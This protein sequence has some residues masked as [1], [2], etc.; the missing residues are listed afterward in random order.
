MNFFNEIKK[1]FIKNKNVLLLAFLIFI[2]PFLIGFLFKP[3]FYNIFE[4]IY[5]HLSQQLKEGVI[6]FSFAGIFL[7]NLAVLCRT[8]I[9]GAIFGISAI[10]LLYNALS[11]GY[12]L[13]GEQIFRKLLLV[14]PHGIFEFSSLIIGTA[15][16]FL[17][18]KFLYNFI[19]ANPLKGFYDAFDK[20]F[21]IIYHSLILFGVAVVLMVIAGFIEVYLTI[22]I[23]LFVLSLL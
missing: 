13:G 11:S 15:A 8:F 7:N 18:F 14:I 3:Y 10:L 19:K 1:A 17:L 12:F 22:L 23:A 21:E 4:P 6:E 5:N 16:G 20:N 2:I 9:L